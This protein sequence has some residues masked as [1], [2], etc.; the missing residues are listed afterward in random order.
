MADLEPATMVG[1]K[2]IFF[3]G[4]HPTGGEEEFANFTISDAKELRDI[5]K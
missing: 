4:G 5:I 1:A 3:K 2:S